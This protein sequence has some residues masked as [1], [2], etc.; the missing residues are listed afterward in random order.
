[1][2][3]ENHF[4]RNY[5]KIRKIIR[6]WYLY[7]CYTKE[8]YMEKLNISART[9]DLE[10]NRL[11]SCIDEK[12][13]QDK[14]TNRKKEMA[15]LYNKF[16]DSG[17]YFF[18]TYKLC[19]YTQKYMLIYFAILQVLYHEKQKGHP[20][21][22][23]IQIV[24]MIQE[25]EQQDLNN[26]TDSEPADIDSKEIL[27]KLNDLLEM[28]VVESI[29]SKGNR[30]YRLSDNPLDQF[31]TEELQDIFYAAEIY[32]AR[33]Y[34]AAPALFLQ[35]QIAYYL[36]Y[37]RNFPEKLQEICIYQYHFLQNILNDDLIYSIKEAILARKMI[38][39][40]KYN[41]KPERF[42]PCRLMTEYWYGRQ[43][44]CVIE[45]DTK[46]PHCIRIDFIQ[47]IRILPEHFSFEPYIKQLEKFEKNWCA[48]IPGSRTKLIEIDFFTNK[49]NDSEIKQMLYADLHGGTAVEINPHH[50][51]YQVNVSDPM[52]MIP[53]IRKFGPSAKVK[54]STCHT[55]AEDLASDWEEALRKY[56][57]VS[58]R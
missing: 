2:A 47:N 27:R 25:Q 9:Y 5:D 37:N 31:D 45:P 10:V 4:I 19:A 20:A 58:E 15:F 57:A 51:S 40:T 55:L 49:E 21:C 23:P 14:R 22:S 7:G 13:Y 29:G 6:N 41:K 12:H 8:E 11:K 26:A 17:N 56:D 1:M 36:K 52:E 30:T 43:Y 3:K 18:Q 35:D 33:N 44:V 24:S 38:E 32:A 42:I 54:K 39:L 16:R 46:E 53:W 48:V 50:I 34:C 28:N